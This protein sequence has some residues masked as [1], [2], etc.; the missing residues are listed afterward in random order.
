MKNNQSRIDLLAL[1]TFEQAASTKAESFP[2]TGLITTRE[3]IKLGRRILIAQAILAGKTRYEVNNHLSVSPNTFAQVHRWLENELKSYSSAYQLH[4]GKASK[5]H[6]HSVQKFSIQH[7]KKAYPGH[8]LLV[9]LV[10]E[11]FSNPNK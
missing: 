11:L 6:K 10:E 8:F 1:K 7:F 4:P 5:S 2:L 3:Q 9:S